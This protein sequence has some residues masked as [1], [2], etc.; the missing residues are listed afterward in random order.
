MATLQVSLTPEIRSSSETLCIPSTNPYSQNLYEDVSF[1]E[2]WNG[3]LL[4][5]II[6]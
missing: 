5:A 2:L 3:T 1:T 6:T 4:N